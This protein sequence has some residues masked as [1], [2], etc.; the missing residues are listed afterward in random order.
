[1]KESA[2]QAANTISEKAG[3]LRD[4]AAAKAHEVGNAIREGAAKADET[5]QESLSNGKTNSAA[6]IPSEQPKP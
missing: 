5:I 6:A 3:E 4:S 1:M 2:K